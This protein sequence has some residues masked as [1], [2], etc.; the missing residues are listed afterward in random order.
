MAAR[1][2]SGSPRLGSKLESGPKRSVLEEE[3]NRKDFA[4]NAKLTRGI[5]DGLCGNWQDAFDTILL[6]FSQIPT[7]APPCCGLEES[8]DSWCWHCWHLLYAWAS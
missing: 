7:I 3:R 6:E 5:G 8:L 1:N 2:F 4:A